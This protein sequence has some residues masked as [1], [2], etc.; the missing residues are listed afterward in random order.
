MVDET[1][2]PFPGK[3]KV[4]NKRR[5]IDPALK[6]KIALEALRGRIPISNLAREYELHPNQIHAWKRLL[7]DHAARLF[8]RRYLGF[9]AV[10]GKIGQPIAESDSLVSKVG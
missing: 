1:G 7:Q 3:A 6:A 5:R 9:V 2:N 10:Q 4:Q 8:D